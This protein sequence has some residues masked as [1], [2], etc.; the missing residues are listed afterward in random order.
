MIATSELKS[1]VH[2]I[3]LNYVEQLGLTSSDI[4]RDGSFTLL[5]DELY[6]INM[7][8]LPDGRIALGSRLL[9]LQGEASA[10]KKEEALIYLMNL[11]AAMIRDHA[12]TLCLN[13]AGTTLLLQRILGSSTDLFKLKTELAEFINS[14][15]F[16]LKVCRKQGLE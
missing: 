12:C 2:P 3:L 11:S 14:L 10:I 5:V 6:R 7:Y 16:W 4:R 9:S 13:E 8:T 1:T 15:E